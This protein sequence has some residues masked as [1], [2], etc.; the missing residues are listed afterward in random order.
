MYFVNGKTLAIF[1]YW[2]SF[3]VIN[4]QI[5]NKQS[6]QLVT[7]LHYLSLLFVFPPIATV[8][9]LAVAFDEMKKG[10]LKKINCCFCC[11]CCLLEVFDTQKPNE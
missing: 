2:K 5:L 10:K 1:F 9:I 3:P 7:L 4:G 6:S 11:C 8:I